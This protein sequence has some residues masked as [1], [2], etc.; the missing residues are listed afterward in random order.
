MK[1]RR[2][3]QVRGRNVPGTQRPA[4]PPALE[5]QR[6]EGIPWRTLEQQVER[7]QQRIARASQQGETRAVHT[8]QQEL[9]ASESARLLAVRRVTQ[10]NEGKDTAGV[11]GVKSLSPTERLAM[12]A[13]IHPSHWNGQRPKPVRRVW[14]PKPGTAEQR[15][16]GILPMIDRCK[17]AL[18]KLALEPEWE[19]QFEP[20][21]YGFRPARSAQDAIRAIVRAIEHQPCF[22]FDADIEA[23]FDHVN[24]AALLERL[25]TYPALRQAIHA[26][27]KAGVMDGTTYVRSDVGIIQGGVLSP[28]LMN[29]ALHGMEE[30]VT[31]SIT[32]H[33]RPALPLLVRYADDLVILHPSLDELHQAARRL[34]QWLAPMGLHLNARKTRIVHTLTPFQGQVGFDF[35]GFALRQYPVVQPA[36]AAQG[37]KTRI[38]RWFAPVPPSVPRFKT[39]I[40]PSEEASKR[41][42]ALIG[43]RLL[44]LQAATQAQVIRNL[45]PLIAGWAAYYRELVSAAVMSRYDAQVDQLLLAWAERRHPDKGRDW[46]RTRYWQRAGQGGRVFAAPEGL[47]LCAYQQPEMPRQRKPG[48]EMNDV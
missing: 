23:A 12:T 33:H 13:A 44:K 29:I 30:A 10:E 46:L 31:G 26:W 18:V 22:V 17:Q 15:P 20:H 27:L 2:I 1:A 16:L 9:I 21:S 32:T 36:S 42:L 25:H 38:T 7:L 43:Q 47:Q 11:D 5:R 3:P 37:F 8:L 24:Q 14:V 48:K 41:H 6:W 35:L 39:V 19:A 4:Q 34:R 40:T 45:N 28:L